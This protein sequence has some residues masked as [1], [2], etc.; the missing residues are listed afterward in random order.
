MLKLTRLTH[1]NC[2]IETTKLSMTAPFLD[3][4]GTAVY[5]VAL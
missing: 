4:G 1:P 2:G 3:V 5:K